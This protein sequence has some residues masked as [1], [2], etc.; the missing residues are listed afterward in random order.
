M[1]AVFIFDAVGELEEIVVIR[2]QMAAVFIV[3]DIREGRVSVSL[4]M[5]WLAACCSQDALQAKL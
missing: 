4:S 5:L 2:P 3:T 1:A